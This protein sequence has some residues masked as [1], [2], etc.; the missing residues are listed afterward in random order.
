MNFDEMLGNL[1]KSTLDITQVKR[2][3]QLRIVKEFKDDPRLSK[4]DLITCAQQ[5]GTPGTCCI[6]SGNGILYGCNS[7]YA[8]CK[9]SKK[10]GDHKIVFVDNPF[11]DYNHKKHIA[12]LKELYTKG[13]HPKYVTVRDIMTKEQCKEAD[14]KY[15]SLE[16]IL[17][18][19]DEIQQYAENVIIIPKY[20]C[21]DKLDEKYILGYSVPTAY[22]G[23][24]LPLEMFKGRKIH[25]LGGSPNKQIA[26]LSELINE[27]VSIDG[28]YLRKLAMVGNCWFPD[29]T[30]V[31]VNDINFG[32]NKL[33]TNQVNIFYIAISISLCNWASYYH[34]RNLDTINEFRSSEEYS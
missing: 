9:N 32:A 16:Q 24:E 27:V 18:W 30:T 14:I 22:G 13:H 6:A 34:K 12:Y 3:D 20:D 4:V 2:K 15:F 29:G 10:E 25:I 21:F 7:S 11:K 28:N 23:T 26:V 8:Y 17:E 5:A 1:N 31:N 19:A 33:M